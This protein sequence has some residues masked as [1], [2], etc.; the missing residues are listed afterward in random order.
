M[1]R[2]K[3]LCP[4]C[5]SLYS[6]HEGA[7]ANDGSRVCRE[8]GAVHA[9]AAEAEAL[10]AARVARLKRVVKWG[11]LG[12]VAAALTVPTTMVVWSS[13]RHSDGAIG[14]A[15]LEQGRA[16][17]SRVEAL[18]RVRSAKLEV[19]KAR[20]PG[21]E[22][23]TAAAAIA[24]PP[25]KQGSDLEGQ[26]WRTYSRELQSSSSPYELRGAVAAP[27]MIRDDARGPR[28]RALS[29]TVSSMES[30]LSQGSVKV[31]LP[32]LP[33][34]KT[35]ARDVTIVL[36]EYRSPRLLPDS[37]EFES[38]RASGRA[39]LYDYER[40]EV[41]CQGTFEA[42]NTDTF[43]ATFREEFGAQRTSDLASDLHARIV[44]Q[45]VRSLRAP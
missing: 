17:L 44:V 15:A 41:L 28:L 29:S 8:C 24:E 7:W 36:D 26:L 4:G 32:A 10:T 12:L 43:V 18:D 39:F 11:A 38:G 37:H 21:L 25:M 27:G 42:T 40:G 16:E 45:A 22:P 34:A 33:D 9:K 31:E 35:W 14:K 1:T 6:E 5:G 13:S 30:L 19:A 20:S 23:C 2:E 3:A